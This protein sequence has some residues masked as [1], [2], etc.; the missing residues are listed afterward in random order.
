MDATLSS[1]ASSNSSITSA[2]EDSSSVLSSKSSLTTLVSCFSASGQEK[3]CC[4]VSVEDFPGEQPIA[5]WENR[6]VISPTNSHILSQNLDK[7]L[8][9][10]HNPSPKSSVKNS[11]QPL[12]KGSFSLGTDSK[13]SL[14]SYMQFTPTIAYKFNHCVDG[15]ISTYIEEYRNS[16]TYPNQER[17]KRSF[18]ST[19]TLVKPTLYTLDG[20][21]M[22]LQ[23]PLTNKKQVCYL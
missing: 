16:Y 17:N 15:D 3:L 6:S 18:A 12:S 23:I 19:T 4:C 10:E 7:S 9:L 20:S 11:K 8:V 21:V 13:S 14:R 22:Q 1:A 2:E 5:G